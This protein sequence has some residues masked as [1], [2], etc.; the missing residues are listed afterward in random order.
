M[1]QRV[2]FLASLGL[3]AAMT[4]CVSVPA[5]ALSKTQL[6]SETLAITDMP[7]G[8]AVDN[9]QAEGS[10]DQGCLAGL[11]Q[12]KHETKVAVAYD[13]GG[14]PE[15][16]EEL[17]TGPGA[18]TAYT[19]LAKALNSCK[20][21]KSTS[22]GQTQTIHV[23]VMS[24]PAVAQESS[25]YQMTITVQGINAGGDLVLFHQGAVYGAVLYAD[26][27]EPDVSIAERYVTKAVAKVRSGSST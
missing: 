15:F 24:F 26:L 1:K 27:G 2:A 18:K 16:E 9:S 7:A 8:W 4:L 23:G 22:S 10:G 20:G 12:A 25:A 19:K 11:K 21:Y 17:T 13:K 6:K 14:I 3:V 5:G